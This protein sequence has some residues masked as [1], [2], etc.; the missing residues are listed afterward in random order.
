MIGGDA[1]GFVIDAHLFNAYT[2]SLFFGFS[3]ILYG[4]KETILKEFILDLFRIQIHMGLHGSAG[5]FWILLFQGFQHHIKVLGLMLKADCAQPYMKPDSEHGDVQVLQHLY[6]FLV[7][8]GLVEQIVEPGIVI[9][10][11]T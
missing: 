4:E 9:V 7:A 5:P 6:Q 11:D 2:E 8:G 10:S 1:L 3:P